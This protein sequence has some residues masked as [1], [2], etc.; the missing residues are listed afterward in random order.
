K[1]PAL[2]RS[3]SPVDSGYASEIDGTDGPSPDRNQQL[4]AIRADAFERDFTERWLCGLIA[5]I[6]SA[7]HISLDI[8]QLAHDRA[9]SILES[10]FSSAVECDD[11]E[12]GETTDFTHNF[13]F[14]L[15]HPDSGPDGKE[16]DV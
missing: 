13:S 6:E 11:D 10:L 7:S 4:A 8:R 1:L 5:R 14:T 16:S 3:A 2:S 9:A 12:D 15:V